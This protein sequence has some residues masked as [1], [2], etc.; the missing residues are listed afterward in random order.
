MG[1]YRRPAHG[2]RLCLCA[3]LT[4]GTLANNKLQYVDA[5]RGLAIMAVLLVHCGQHGTNHYPAP[6]TQAI[7]NGQMGV[8]LFF[9]MSAFTLFLSYVNRQ[10][11]ERFAIRNFFIRR[12]FRIAPMY[13]LGI[14]YYLPSRLCRR[15]HGP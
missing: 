8:Q 14:A 15:G 12:V 4:T 1:N 7:V 3:S 11:R 2:A 5:I 9:V 6:I 13:W 10:G